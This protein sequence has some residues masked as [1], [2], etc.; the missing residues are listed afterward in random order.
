MR[1]PARA[2]A[3]VATLLGILTLTAACGG[4][5]KSEGT[6]STTPKVIDITV[7][8]GSVT[9][10]G[11]VVEVAKGQKVE[12]EVKADAAGKI[13]VHSDP[14]KEYEYGVGTTRISVGSFD[15]AG[16]IEVESH[17]LGTTI[18]TLEVK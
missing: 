4:D 2:L 3:I 11:E 6:D 18:V 15:L 13:R 9:P 1:H 14:A 17:A 5:T 16:R 10:N 8:D 7:K 12:F